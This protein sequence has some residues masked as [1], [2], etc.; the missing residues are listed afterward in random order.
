MSMSGDLSVDSLF[1]KPETGEYT[2]K[3]Q[4]NDKFDESLERYSE[5]SSEFSFVVPKTFTL[6]N[7]ISAVGSSSLPPNSCRRFLATVLKK[8]KQYNNTINDTTEVSCIPVLPPRLYEEFM[9]PKGSV[10]SKRNFDDAFDG[11]GYKQRKSKKRTKKRKSKKRTKRS[12]KSKKR[13]KKRKS[14]KR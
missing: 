1:K 2:T 6:E 10:K 5:S 4:F 12:R 14:K 3:D 13:T 7:I 9:K 8:I 11:G